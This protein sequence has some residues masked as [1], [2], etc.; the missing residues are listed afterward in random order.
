MIIM[1][2][3]PLSSKLMTMRTLRECVPAIHLSACHQRRYRD[4]QS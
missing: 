4:S 3:F 1:M 2:M